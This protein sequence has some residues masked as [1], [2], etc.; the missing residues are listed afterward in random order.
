[1]ANL[2]LGIYYNLTIWYKLTEKTIWG[3]YITLFG[4]LITLA[5]NFILIPKIGY[6]GAAIATLICYALM[7]I[8]SFFLGQ[9][10]FPIPYQPFKI[11]LFIGL[12]LLFYFLNHL[13]WQ[14]APQVS[15]LL[16]LTVKTAGIVLFTALCLLIEKRWKSSQS[17]FPQKIN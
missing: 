3:A 1:L 13:L 9:H 5:A 6:L 11:L 14:S 2:A 12:A 10:F 17:S 16:R 15:T 4:A 7:T 8:V